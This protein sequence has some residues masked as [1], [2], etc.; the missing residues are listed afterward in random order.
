MT[1]CRVIYRYSKKQRSEKTGKRSL[2]K[3]ETAEYLDVSK[4]STSCTS[5]GKRG[6]SA[7]DSQDAHWTQCDYGNWSSF[8]HTNRF[9]SRFQRH[10]Q[11]LHTG[12]HYSS[13]IWQLLSSVTARDASPTTLQPQLI[14]MLQT[15]Q[16]CWQQPSLSQEKWLVAACS[17]GS[18]AAHPE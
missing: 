2:D 13:V 4:E 5:G 17:A 18:K 8:P 10:T 15:L 9:I 6:L 12:S 16:H 3:P 7:F 11:M 1:S 14:L